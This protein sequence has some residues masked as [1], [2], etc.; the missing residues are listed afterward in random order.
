MYLSLS[1]PDVIQCAIGPLHVAYKQ[2]KDNQTQKD[3]ALP[4]A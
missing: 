3:E 4:L 1:T 2:W